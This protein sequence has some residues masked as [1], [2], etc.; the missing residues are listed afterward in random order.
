MRRKKRRCD[1]RS[2]KDAREG[3]G[4]GKGGIHSGGEELGEGSDAVTWVTVT[5]AAKLLT[6]NHP[7]WMVSICSH[8]REIRKERKGARKRA[9][10]RSP[11]S[12]A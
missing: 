2:N 8:Y 6:S 4:T 12:T 10:G 3:G 7:P 5:T 11:I 1:R 9:V